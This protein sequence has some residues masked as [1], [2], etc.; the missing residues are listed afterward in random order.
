MHTVKQSVVAHTLQPRAVIGKM[1]G[2]DKIRLRV[3]DLGRTTDTIGMRVIHANTTPS[4]ATTTLSLFS[5]YPLFPSIIQYSDSVF[6]TSTASILADNHQ[7]L[8]D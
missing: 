4:P 2:Y 1:N 7:A 8:L 5:K 3:S 6:A